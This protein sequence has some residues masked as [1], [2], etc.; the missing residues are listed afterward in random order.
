MTE[1]MS[2][3]MHQGENLLDEAVED[4]ALGRPELL[5]EIIDDTTE[6]KSIRA[7][8][9]CI[10]HGRRDAAIE[11]LERAL[12]EACAMKAIKY[13]SP[14]EVAHRASMLAGD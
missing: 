11:A 6:H 13:Y 2:H 3:H 12:S 10:A 8:I 5:A 14:V 9:E 1:L 4:A 7:A